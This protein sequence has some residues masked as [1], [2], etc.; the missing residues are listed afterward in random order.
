MLTVE[1]RMR[2][3][4]RA[5]KKME[6]AATRLN[7]GIGQKLKTVGWKIQEESKE[8]AKISPV[9]DTDRGG[10]EKSI[11][12][13]VSGHKLYIYVPDNSLA[14]KYAWIQHDHPGRGSGTIRKGKRADKEFITRAVDDN[15]D[16]IKKTIGSAFDVIT[17]D[18]IR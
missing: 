16:W 7:K 6:K 8:N 1:A 15:E 2:N 9:K 11:L 10:L 4:E 5:I 18:E 3:T 12:W 17:K 13:R 14:G